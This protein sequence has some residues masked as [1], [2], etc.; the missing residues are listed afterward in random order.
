MS[1]II[2]PMNGTSPNV[3]V[4]NG[5]EYYITNWKDLVPTI[6]NIVK[7]IDPVLFNEI[8]DENKIHKSTSTHGN[9]VKDPIITKNKELLKG[10]IKLN[11]SELYVEGVL[12]SSR[13]RFYAKR[14]LDYY[15]LTDSFQIE[16]S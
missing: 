7:E 6:C 15:E 12:S 5:V 2:T 9:N 16:V 4:Y 1:D 13:A 8:V 10:P 14:L 3:I 11:E